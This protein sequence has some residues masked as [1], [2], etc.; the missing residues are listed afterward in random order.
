MPS[1]S[2]KADGKR[3][4]KSC[5]PTSVRDLHPVLGRLEPP[6]EGPPRLQIYLGLGFPRE[7]S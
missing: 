2:P 7:S 1:I 5:E 6:L 4:D 3:G